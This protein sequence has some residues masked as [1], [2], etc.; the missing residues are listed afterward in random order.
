[1]TALTPTRILVA[2]DDSPAAL[3]GVR[4][5][6]DLARHTGARI[7]FVHVLGRRAGAGAARSCTTTAR[8][9]SG[10]RA[11]EHAPAARRRRR[12]SGPACRPWASASRASRVRCCSPTPARGRPTCWWSAA[13]TRPG[14]G[15]RTSARSRVSCSSSAISRSWWSRSPHR[16]RGLRHVAEPVL[17]WAGSRAEAP[18]LAVTAPSERLAPWRGVFLRSGVVIT[19]SGPGMCRVTVPAPLVRSRVTRARAEETSGASYLPLRRVRPRARP[20]ENSPEESVRGRSHLG[21]V[22]DDHRHQR[23]LAFRRRRGRPQAA[24]ALD[25]GGLGVPLGLR[26]D[27]HRLRHRGLG[28]RR[29][30][31]RHRVLRRLAHRVLPLGGQPVHLHHHHGEVR[32]AQGLPADRADGRHRARADHARHLHRRSAPPRSSSSAGSSTSSVSS[33]STPR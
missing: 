12:R 6:V 7:R 15:R 26:R 18:E 25:E 5:A 13:R 9:S 22:D 14:R 19:A 29:A 8:W 11:G 24:R 30:P 23:H 2:V 27:G 21:L 4:L 33:S 3:E 17:R 32:G 16:C 10:G 20:P 1:M 28:A 31:V